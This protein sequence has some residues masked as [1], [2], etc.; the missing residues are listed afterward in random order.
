MDKILIIERL[1]SI[2]NTARERARREAMEYSEPEIKAFILEKG[3]QQLI[4][5]IQNGILVECH[6]NEKSCLYT[7]NVSALK[8][9]DLPSSDKMISYTGCKHLHST[10]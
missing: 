1:F 3:I 6:T 9:D 2:R 5:E 10:I 4:I 8:I 7:S